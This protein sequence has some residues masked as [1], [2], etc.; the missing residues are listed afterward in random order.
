M[1][2][3][4]AELVKKRNR[5][6]MRIKTLEQEIA[7]H[8]ERMKELIASYEVHKNDPFLGKFVLDPRL[9]R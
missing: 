5:L 6:N 9:R 1:R 7:S 8:P 3:Q 4:L 2:E